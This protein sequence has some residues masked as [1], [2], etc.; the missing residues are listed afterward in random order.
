M[1]G[2]NVGSIIARYLIWLI[3]EWCSGGIICGGI[4]GSYD[5]RR[6][7]GGDL[8]VGTVYGSCYMVSPSVNN[9][10]R[11][12]G[13]LGGTMIGLMDGTVPG[14]FCLVSSSGYGVPVLPPS[15]L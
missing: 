11:T 14:I 9:G 5:R 4:I 12:V 15:E 3:A 2:S 13:L 6:M 7:H 10:I 8:D 1:G